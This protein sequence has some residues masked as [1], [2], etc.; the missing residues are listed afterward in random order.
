[1][2]A[3]AGVAP[4]GRLSGR[5]GHNWQYRL[6]LFSRLLALLLPITIASPARS[7]VA[8]SLAVESDYRFRGYSLSSGRPT[9]SV[10]LAYD[11]PSGL[12]LYGSVA[13][14]HRNDGADLLGY[15]ANI[16]YAKRLTPT[17]SVDAGVIHFQSRYPYF[18]STQSSH[19]TE[20]YVA[21]HVREFTA[22]VFYSPHYFRDGVS[23]AYGELDA[24][25]QPS[26]NWRL[27]A[28]VGLLAY[29]TT[30][31]YFDRSTSYDWRLRASRQFGAVEVHAAVTGGGPGK[32]YYGG[33]AHDRTA[34]TVGGSLN[35]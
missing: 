30:P 11:S 21:A 32:D 5:P 3:F 6:T 19:Y 12:Y 16:G 18:G 17:A 34:L 22:R 8:L 23:T 24:A 14:V 1:M 25:I 29:L 13:G 26:A 35:F 10:N 31:V 7:Q 2:I 9:A 15:Q 27:N 28:H 33:A 4:C 20:A